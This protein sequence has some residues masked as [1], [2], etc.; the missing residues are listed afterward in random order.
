[1]S[2]MDMIDKYHESKRVMIEDGGKELAQYLK[3]ICFTPENNEVAAF[4]FTAYTTYFNDGDPCTFSVNDLEYIKFS[5]L[6]ERES[7]ETDLVE[8]VREVI[9]DDYELP[10]YIWSSDAMPGVKSTVEAFGKIPDDLIKSVLGEHVS[11]I[12]T[13]DGITIDEHDQD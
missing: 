13:R 6:D 5:E 10:G 8:R 2:L 4:R 3:S 12:I 11:V 9:E 7:D 1:M